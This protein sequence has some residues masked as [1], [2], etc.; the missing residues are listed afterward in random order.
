MRKAP[1]PRCSYSFNSYLIVLSL[2]LGCASLASATELK[3]NTVAAFNKYVAA[4]EARMTPE[5]RPG[6]AFLFPDTLPPKKRTAAY[7]Q[8]ARGEIFISPL[9]TTVNGKTIDDPDGMIH[10]WV[11]VVF[12]PDSDLG[13]TLLG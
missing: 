13:R 10:H 2:L 5:L 7:Q 6:G 9:Q 12:V 11:R 8:L 4:T 3:P 1:Q